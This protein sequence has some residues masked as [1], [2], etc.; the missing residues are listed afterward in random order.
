MRANKKN[1]LFFLLVFLFF[2]F[3]FYTNNLVRNIGVPLICNN[4]I[5]FGIPIRQTVIFF[6]NGTVILLLFFFTLFFYKNNIKIS[7]ILTVITLGAISNL[8]DRYIYGCIIDFIQ[9]PVYKGFYFNTADIYITLG[10]F[11]FIPPW[12]KCAQTVRN[13]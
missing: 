6:I 12:Y 1:I 11:L 9:L 13:K 5:S 4:G 7:L 2:I 10:G 8:L 3:I